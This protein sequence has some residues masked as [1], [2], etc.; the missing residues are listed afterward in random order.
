[1]AVVKKTSRQSC[2]VDSSIT[3]AW[4]FPDEKS[5]YPEEI[6][7]SIVTTTVW[8]PQLWHLEIANV[9]LMAEK[10]KRCTSSDVAGWLSFLS[11]LTI[12]VDTETIKKAW[13]DI[14]HLGRS[15]GLTTYDAAYLELALRRKAILATLDNK[16][17]NAGRRAGLE[18]M[19]D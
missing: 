17:A 5:S 2:V 4:C 6:L 14:L 15:Q 1:M 12:S 8:V 9:F 7:D 11:A 3:L 13:N 10:K 19:C 16:L 18:V